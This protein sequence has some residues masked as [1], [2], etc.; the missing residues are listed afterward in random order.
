MGGGLGTRLAAQQAIIYSCV[1]TCMHVTIMS[2]HVM[3]DHNVH[4]L[5][6]AVCPWNTSVKVM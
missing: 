6:I 2:M 1:C 4:G 3:A 5:T